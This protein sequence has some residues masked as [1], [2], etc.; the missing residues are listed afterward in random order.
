MPKHSDL[1]VLNERLPPPCWSLL[2][3]AVF[4]EF[5]FIAAAALLAAKMDCLRNKSNNSFF[6]IMQMMSVD[7]RRR[8]SIEHCSS[9]YFVPQLLCC[10]DF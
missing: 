8:V 3:F 1:A 9:L 5:D 2:A 7:R 10:F 4:R 6:L